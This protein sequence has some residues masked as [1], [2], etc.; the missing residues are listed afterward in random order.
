MR[1]RE[2]LSLVASLPIACVIS[3]IGRS[4]LD[5]RDRPVADRGPDPARCQIDWSLLAG[6]DRTADGRIR[7]RTVPVASRNE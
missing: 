1:R 2:L 5:R 4:D 3:R 6:V 7:L